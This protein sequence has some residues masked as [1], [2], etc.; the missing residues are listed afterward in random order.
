MGRS[1]MGTGK[2]PPLPRRSEA[3]EY[4]G[5]WLVDDRHRIVMAG[6][7]VDLISEHL[8][9]PQP[10]PGALEPLRLGRRRKTELTA[11]PVEEQPFRTN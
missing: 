11:A 2:D 7:G 9:R 3:I 10:P 6:Q 5:A 8:P 4:G 1:D